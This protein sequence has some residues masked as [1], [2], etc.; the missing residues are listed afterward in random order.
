MNQEL[1]DRIKELCGL[2]ATEQDRHKFLDLVT[3]LNQLLER[4]DQ[5]LKRSA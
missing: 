3:E 2:I 5:T 4:K 1:D